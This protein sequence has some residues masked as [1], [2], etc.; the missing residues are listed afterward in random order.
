MATSKAQR[1]GIWVIAIAMIIGTVTSFLIL[2]LAPQNQLAD[3][4]ALEQEY[5]KYQ[6]DIAKQRL[7]TSKPLRGYKADTFNAQEVTKLEVEVIKKGTGKVAKADSSVSANY[8][9]WLSD[10]TIFDSSNQDGTTTPIEF[11]LSGV[12]EGWTK[13][14]TGVKA[15]SV[16]KL[17]IPAEQAYGSAGS[18]PN[19]GPNEPLRF[20]VELKE[21]N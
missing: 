12:I 9:G 16:V 17:T 2:I 4:Q 14:L 15:G 1:T 11:S 13:G 20:I 8:F 6:D 19:I 10:G 7:E 21:V 5:Q 3:Q 18:P